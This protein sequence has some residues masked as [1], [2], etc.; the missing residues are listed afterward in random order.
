MEIRRWLSISGSA[1]VD[2][3][4]EYGTFLSPRLSAL[5][6]SGEWTSRMSIGTGFFGPSPLTE[7]TEASGL[8]RLVIPASL[9]AERGQS[10]SVDVTRS[11]GA[12]T[13]TA[14]LFASRIAHPINVDRSAG[15]VL[16]NLDEPATNVG[17]ELIGTLRH[18]PYSVTATYSFV[19]SRETV[20]GTVRDVAL[21]PRHSAGLVAMWEREGVGRVGVEF[22]FTGHQRLEENPYSHTSHAYAILGLLAER[23]VGRFRLFINGE[24]L[25]G[26]RQTKWDPLIRP[27]RAPD[28][29]WTVD[30]WSPLEGRNINGGI[31]LQF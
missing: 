26:V 15:L 20:E 1:R 24:N 8:T 30:A 14:T 19:K 12:L 29:R 21:T 23:Q 25:T 3:H 7:E 16:T 2:H 6:R 22:Y 4:N 13:A 27:T 9:Q 11:H 5:F 18:A 28:G 17:V 10:S 31:R